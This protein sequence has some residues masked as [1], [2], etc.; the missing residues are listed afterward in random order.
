MRFRLAIIFITSLLLCVTWSF[1]QDDSVAN[2]LQNGDFEGNFVALDGADPRNV[3]ESWTPWHVAATGSSP[4]FANH[5]PGY[6][7]ETDRIRLDEA[8]KAQKYFTLFATHQGGIYQKVDS[9]TSGATYRFSIYAYVWSSSF[10]DTEVS[11][12]PGDVVLRVGIDPTG[13]ADGASDNIVWSTAATFFY[14]AYRQYAVIA[15]AEASSITVFVES[16]VGE[17]RANN[18]IYLDD[19]MLETVSDSPVVFDPTP[20]SEQ[21]PGKAGGATVM[22]TATL[23]A[24]ATAP[25]AMA[26]PALDTPP[27][28]RVS[29]EPEPA[30]DLPLSDEYSH[31]HVVVEGDTVSTLANLYGSTAEAIKIANRL[32]PASLITVGQPLQIPVNPHAKEL[33]PLTIDW[34]VSPLVSHPFYAPPE[35]WHEVFERENCSVGMRHVTSPPD[36]IK[37]YHLMMWG[38]HKL[39]YDDP[40]STVNL[41][42]L[43]ECSIAWQVEERERELENYQDSILQH[44]RGSIKL[45]VNDCEATIEMFDLE[46]Y[47]ERDSLGYLLLVD[48]PCLLDFVGSSSSYTGEGS[49]AA[50]IVIMSI[51]EDP[52]LA[53]KGPPPTDTPTATATPT[54]TPTPTFTSTPTFTPTPT[55][56][57]ITYQIQPGDTLVDIASLY[58]TNVDLLVETNNIPNRHQIDVG[59]I[60]LIPTAIPSPTAIPPTLDA[61]V[62]PTVT[63]YPTEVPTL[64]PTAGTPLPPWFTVYIVQIGDTLDEIA[65]EHNTTVQAIV[66]LNEIADPRIILPGQAIKIPSPYPTPT[67]TATP[68]PQPTFTP[69][70]TTIPV[71]YTVQAGD[72]LANIAARYGISALELAQVNGI[73][74][75]QQLTVGQV[76]TIP[77]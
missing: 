48:T 41:H 32:N 1:G 9:L 39:G 23:T 74:N 29:S 75:N 13:G 8:G 12:D 33:T 14:D 72:T 51:S 42:R 64:D 4:S 58:S 7:E 15:T 24:T 44:S 40:D 36:D 3:A 35:P 57:A 30:A 67:P 47:F 45:D 2:L 10:E 43:Q 38:W 26:E 11:E 17:P 76:L 61:T 65:R 49:W 19:A 34:N 50:P 52:A 70:A 54:A 60:L 62:R 27:P 55:A 21:A 46:T 53:S 69:F 25:A 77:G 66:E 31:I 59:Q 18:Y 71:S 20:T 56:T 28:E 6:D 37:P 63:L 68:T 22:P 5:D 16:T 73:G